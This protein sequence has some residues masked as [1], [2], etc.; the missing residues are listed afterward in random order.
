MATSRRKVLVPLATLLA[1]GAVAVGSGATFTSTSTN[2]ASAVTSGTL[3]QSNSKA[4]R[5]IFEVTD[6]KPGDVVNGTLTITNTGSL[7]ATFSLT[8]TSSSNGFSGA[9]LDLTITN[10]TT[11]TEIYSG[12]FGGLVDGAKSD[13]GVVQ[14][15]EANEYLFRVEL[16]EGTPNTDQ[17]KT[18]SAAYQWD[19]VQL[20]G[21]TIDQ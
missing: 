21:E 12:P 1:A 20:D 9:N 19:S 14:P 16:A 4:D 11:G 3:S 2:A 10:T 18:A 7:P 6:I 17:G 5:A 8:E 15:D 13:L